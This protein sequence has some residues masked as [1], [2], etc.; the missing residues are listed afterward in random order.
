MVLPHAEPVAERGNGVSVADRLASLRAEIATEAQACGRDPAAIALVGVAKRQPLATVRE[1][2]AA[3]L[4]DVAENYAQ[5]AR[6]AFAHL[7]AV[8]RH[9]VGHVQRNKAAAIEELFDVVQSV[10]RLEAG[11][12]LAQAAERAGRV[13]AVLV[14]LNVSEGERFG[15]P[16][17]EGERLADALRSSPSLRVDGVMAIGP[18]TAER[19]EIARAFERAAMTFARIGG[20]TLSM[21]MSGDWREAVR[22]GSTMLR[23]GTALF[24][25]RSR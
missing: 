22:A 6:A 14:Q 1:A 3:G 15:C 12:A 8:R 13:L 24:G 21:G 16:P 10:D 25:S 18:L 23:I 17:Q 2:I 4:T 5:E 9:F 7:P 20:S 11:V 19:D